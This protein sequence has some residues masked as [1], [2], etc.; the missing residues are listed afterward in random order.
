MLLRGNRSWR[1]FRKKIENPYFEKWKIQLIFQKKNLKRDQ[2]WWKTYN[3]HYTMQ[4]HLAFDFPGLHCFVCE[5]WVWFYR[6]EYW[7]PIHVGPCTHGRPDTPENGAFQNTTQRRVYLPEVEGSQWSFDKPTAP[8]WYDF[9]TGERRG[10]WVTAHAP[11]EKILLYVRAG[12]EPTF[13]SSFLEKSNYPEC[14]GILPLGPELQWTGEKPADPLEI[15]VYILSMFPGY[16]SVRTTDWSSPGM[17]PG[18]DGEFTLYEDDGKT[19]DYER[20][21]FSTVKMIWDDSRGQLIIDQLFRK[22]W[23]TVL[24]QNTN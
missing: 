11:I 17:H 6:A 21:E 15:R 7:W 16:I 8:G 3:E 23:R 14:W 10:G 9:W 22:V 18:S 13:W 1:N 12:S 5:Q 19:R 20:G 2:L 4:R 24:I